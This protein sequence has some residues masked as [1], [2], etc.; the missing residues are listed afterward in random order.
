[1]DTL[2]SPFYKSS[3][4]LFMIPKSCWKRHQF[5]I[6]KLN[7]NLALH[8]YSVLDDT[9]LHIKCYSVGIMALTTPGAGMA[10]FNFLPLLTRIFIN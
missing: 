8:P 6:A 2:T 1:M 3:P 5:I 10:S 7:A 9:H 4:A